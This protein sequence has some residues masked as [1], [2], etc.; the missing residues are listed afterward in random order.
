MDEHLTKQSLAIQSYF[1]NDL[2]PNKC[3][4]SILQWQATLFSNHNFCAQL[5]L[6]GPHRTTWTD[7][8]PRIDR[9]NLPFNGIN[10]PFA[11]AL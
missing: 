4:Q 9:C 10:N 8:T 5:E 6:M 3:I 7:L 2:S 11:S 1:L